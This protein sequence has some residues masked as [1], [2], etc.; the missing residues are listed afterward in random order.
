M[1]FL[2]RLYI[3]SVL[4]VIGTAL[5]A[6]AIYAQSTLTSDKSDYPPGDTATLTGTGFL[7]DETVT[8]QVHHADAT[9]DSGVDHQPWTVVADSTGG[10]VTTWHVC[11][12]DCLGKLL[13]A[14][15]DGQSSNLHSEVLFTDANTPQINSVSTTPFSPNQ[16]SSAGVKDTTVITAQNGT[17]STITDF[18][19]RIHGPSGALIK[20]FLFSNVIKNGIVTPT[21]D[22][23]NTSGTFV[24]DSTYNIYASNGTTETTS[25]AN[26]IGSAVVD[27][28][29]PTVTLNSPA[30]NAVVSG[31]I[32]LDASPLD[33]GGNDNNIDKVEFYV[34]GNLVGTDGSSGGGWTNSF[35]TT[36][37]TDG[38]H[39]WNAKAFDKAG[40]NTTSGTRTFTV[41][42]TGTY[43]AVITPTTAI[44]GNSVPYTITV[45]NTTPQVALAMGSVT[46]AIPTGAGTPTSV[47]VTATDPGPISRTWSV[48]LTALPDS[49]RFS[50]SGASANDIDSGGTVVIQFNATATSTGSKVWRTTAFVNNN[51]TQPFNLQGSQPTVTVCSSLTVTTNPSN[52]TVCAGSTATFTASASSTPS[53][54][55]QWQV[56][57]GSGFTNIPGATSTTLS[58]TTSA[59]QNGYQYRAVFSN[60]CI[61][62]NSS[63]AT[64]TVN[65]APV[66]TCPGNITKNNG[67]D[68]CG[69]IVNF[70]ATATGSPAPTITYSPTAG[71]F[72]PIGTSV[73]KAKATNTCGS[74]SCTFTVTVN[75]NQ[76]PKI[77]CPTNIVKNTDPGQCS[78][79]VSFTV[80][81]T[82][83]CPGVTVISTPASGSTFPKGT[84][85][86]KSVAT[87]AA[88]N[89]DSCSFT[90]T[91]NDTEPP[92][93]T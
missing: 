34:D 43:T 14:T 33:A 46:V 17:N 36:T 19:V 54:T 3:I 87:D 50:R 4:L 28:T 74:D 62:V 59:S 81:A 6:Q 72:F 7:P 64:L 40:N 18:R 16:P 10:F 82:D 65:T 24:G 56:N 53:P 30:D 47:T 49:L 60:V 91:I 41:R 48:D 90:V 77:T 44:T 75:D 89:K 55:V 8:L 21:W 20:E 51:Y 63:A 80:T 58:F 26:V 76:K 70:S 79:V 57:T 67:L 23:K 52:Q 35:N 92:K 78:A 13:K 12:D 1:E 83:N 22:G 5:S 29:N 39:S 31:T 71:S 84:T 85:T 88:G 2:K 32:T 27:N 25:P 11:E 93:I 38:N 45:T 66:I 15:A 37:V 73:V 86:V 69:T 68:S 61:S 9:P 42:N